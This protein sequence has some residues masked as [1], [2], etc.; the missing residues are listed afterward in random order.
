MEVMVSNVRV[1]RSSSHLLCGAFP[2]FREF[3]SIS[4][5]ALLFENDV[6][7]D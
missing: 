3:A 6:P 1:K 5:F 7:H 4:T 2:Q